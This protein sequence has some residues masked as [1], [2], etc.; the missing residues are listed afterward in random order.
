VVVTNQSGIAR[1]YYTEADFAALTAWMVQRFAEH[2]VALAGVYFCPHHPQQ[3]LA[4]YV[5]RCGCRKPA[6]GLLWQAIAA[7]AI[8]PAR[9]VMVGDKGADMEAAAAAGVAQRILV[10]SGQPFTDDET[11]LATA[12]WPDLWAFAQSHAGPP[13]AT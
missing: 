11:A 9:S 2:G 5:Q 8:D 10:R 13:P 1:G 7:H 4:P 12:V 3:G 6:P